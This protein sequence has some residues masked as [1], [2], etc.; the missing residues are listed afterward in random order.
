MLIDVTRYTHAWYIFIESN[1]YNK[2]KAITN[3]KRR[4]WRMNP[5]PFLVWVF[6]K[7]ADVFEN[8]KKKTSIIRS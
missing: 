8:L 4:W 7:I 5:N 6:I 3:G 1:N 2:N